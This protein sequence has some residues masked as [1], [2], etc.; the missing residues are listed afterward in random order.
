MKVLVIYT[1]SDHYEIALNGSPIAHLQFADAERAEIVEMSEEEY[2]AIPV[3]ED[4][5]R[6]FGV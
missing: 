3:A 1:N 4:G 5:E 2:E 6:R